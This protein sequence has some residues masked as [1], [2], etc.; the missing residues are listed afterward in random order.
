MAYFHPSTKL[1]KMS[2]HGQYRVSR[3]EVRVAERTVDSLVHPW[4]FLACS[5]H[6]RGPEITINHLPL[7]RGWEHTAHFSGRW[8]T[9][10]INCF[11]TLSL[12]LSLPPLPRVCTCVW[13]G[14]GDREMGERTRK[15]I[16]KV[17][18]RE[19]WMPLL[20]RQRRV[21]KNKAPRSSR[22]ENQEGNNRFSSDR[23]SPGQ[24]PLSRL[25][26]RLF[27]VYSENGHLRKSAEKFSLQFAHQSIGPS[28]MEP[29]HPTLL[30]RD[31]PLCPQI[32]VK[33]QLQSLQSH[34]Y[35]QI[36]TK[37]KKGLFWMKSHIAFMVNSFE[38]KKWF[39]FRKKSTYIYI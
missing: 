23:S 1:R 31:G 20:K 12:S 22:S 16:H 14:G 28:P 19:K 21:R 25:S 17:I 3:R 33:R 37:P 32:W 7:Q 6:P 10:S 15:G 34:K 4:S 24:I 29:A 27:D 8:H 18:I 13:Q 11:Q 26:L 38:L 30:A 35:I 5:F 2:Q 36:Q 39:G 9:F